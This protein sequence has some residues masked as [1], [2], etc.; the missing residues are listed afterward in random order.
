MNSELFKGAH[1]VIGEIQR[2]LFPQLESC[3]DSNNAQTIEG[4]INTKIK[5]LELI[6][7]KLYMV[8]NKNS[9]LKY[10]YEQLRFVL[11]IIL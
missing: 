5:S 6:L 4:S 11:I 10:K 7:E 8:V 1:N 2:S 3:R 9:S